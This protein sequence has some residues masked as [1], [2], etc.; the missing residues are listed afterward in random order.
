MTTQS[1]I[2]NRDFGPQGAVA[3]VGLMRG[4]R[5][6]LSLGRIGICTGERYT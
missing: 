5:W 1:I 4:M 6:R 3:P 2:R